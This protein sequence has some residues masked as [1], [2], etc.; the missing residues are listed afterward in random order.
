MIAYAETRIANANAYLEGFS[1]S[2]KGDLEAVLAALVEAFY[3]NYGRKI[4]NQ[5][6]IIPT[7]FPMYIDSYHCRSFKHTNHK[8]NF[9]IAN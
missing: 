3:L 8:Q 1:L 4:R 6:A 5:M 2:L 7:M 9:N